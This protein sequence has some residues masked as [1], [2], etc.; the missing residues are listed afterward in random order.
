MT[1]FLRQQYDIY[2]GLEGK[3]IDIHLDVY[4]QVDI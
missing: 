1:L 4:I 2:I 3:Q